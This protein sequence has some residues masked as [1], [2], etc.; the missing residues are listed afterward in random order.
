VY[1][2]NRSAALANLGRFEDALSDAK[3]AVKLKPGWVKGHARAG[4]AHMGLQQYGDA[5]EAYERAVKLEPDDQVGRGDSMKTLNKCKEKG[6]LFLIGVPSLILVVLF[7]VVGIGCCAASCTST[8]MIWSLADTC[9][10]HSSFLHACTRH[11][12]V[13]GDGGAEV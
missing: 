7:A 1:Y 9:G 10:L 4:A 6:V 13:G 3:R 12:F 5:R 11:V 2:S 8:S